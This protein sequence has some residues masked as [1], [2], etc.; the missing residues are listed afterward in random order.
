M[1]EMQCGPHRFVV[2]AMGGRAIRGRIPGLH[3]AARPCIRSWEARI[4]AEQQCFARG[5]F[6]L[7]MGPR[8]LPA[9][10]CPEAL[11]PAR[12]D[13]I[14]WKILD[15]LQQN[16]RITNVE[17]ARRVGISAPPCLRRMR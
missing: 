8:R 11:V 14:D 13:A 16:G 17:L 2:P 4:S 1:Q 5:R 6:T 9:P 7:W 15:E 10:P 12:L 3:G